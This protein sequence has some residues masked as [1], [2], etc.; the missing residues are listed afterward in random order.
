MIHYEPKHGYL[1]NTF[2]PYKF[3]IFSSNLYP[4]GIGTIVKFFDKSK[5]CMKLKDFPTQ[6]LCKNFEKIELAERDILLE[7]FIY[8]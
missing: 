1:K 5:A 2:A 4:V 8:C 6:K 3:R 7:K